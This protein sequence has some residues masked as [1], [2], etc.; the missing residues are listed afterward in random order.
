ML[1]LHNEMNGHRNTQQPPI[2]WGMQRYEGGMGV[3]R[4][5]WAR[6]SARGETEE[7]ADHCRFPLGPRAQ[8]KLMSPF[9]RS[10]L[11]QK[12]KFHVKVMGSVLDR[13]A[14]S[15]R[16][17]QEGRPIFMSSGMNNVHRCSDST[18]ARISTP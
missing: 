2:C 6:Y 9:G 3:V 4:R 14:G 12:C 18:A 17:L 8:L 11:F 5:I 10:P 15:V 1:D 13:P 7:E 16:F